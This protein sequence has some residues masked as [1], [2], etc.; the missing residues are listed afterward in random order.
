MNRGGDQS[1][2]LER[3]AGLLSDQRRFNVQRRAFSER[4]ELRTLLSGVAAPTNAQ[5][6]S[7][8]LAAY[9]AHD[10]AMGPISPRK[11]TVQSFGAQ[12]DSPLNVERHVSNDQF[13]SQLRAEG[14][15]SSDGGG[16][17]TREW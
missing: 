7:V 1:R 14:E 12:T 11:Q 10:H 15:G 6:D 8:S 5:D 9:V 17:E 16:G 4:L 13:F 3:I 2:W